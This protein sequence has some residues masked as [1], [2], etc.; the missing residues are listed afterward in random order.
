MRS[1]YHSY[2]KVVKG[3]MRVKRFVSSTVNMEV[4]CLVYFDLKSSIL[5]AFT[6]E[7]FSTT[8]KNG[9]VHTDS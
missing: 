9:A 8:T 5:L 6:D 4:F 7:N 3:W 2:Y 1:G